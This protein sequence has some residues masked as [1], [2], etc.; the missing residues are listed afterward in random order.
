MLYLKNCIILNYG[1]ETRGY[2]IN[3]RFACSINAKQ[4]AEV[5]SGY[6]VLSTNDLSKNF[7]LN[8]ILSTY[9]SQ[10][11]VERGFRF[12]KSPDFLVSSF[13]LKKTERIEAL[14]MVMTLCLLI[15]SAIEHKVRKKLKENGEYFL[16][17]KK[18]SA[19]NPT[20][21]WI[22]FCFLGLHL[23]LINNKKEQI[24]NLKK[25]HDIILNCLGPPYKKLYYSE[26]W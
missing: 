20:S 23:I 14:L 10:Q 15:Y 5:Q 16:N 18:K 25:R 6:F 2:Q 1:D 7:S 19:Q 3:G 4:D 8:E 13:F 17:Q 22:F 9:K 12:L 11:S 26:L 24:T 21:R